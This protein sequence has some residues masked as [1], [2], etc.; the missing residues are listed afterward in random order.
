M[1]KPFLTVRRYPY[2]E[3]L[4]TQIEI[5]ASNG[6]FAGTTDIY[7][8]VQ[9]LVEIGGGLKNFPKTADDEYRY[10][11]RSED[12]ALRCY[13]YFL[14][15]AYTTDAVGH[16]ALQIKMNCNASQPNEGMCEFSIRAE[17]AA[18]NRLGGLLEEFSKLG[19]LELHWRLDEGELF[20]DLQP[21]V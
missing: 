6:F 12:P 20:E 16:S 9:D 18:I 17:A 4:N 13:R 10:E 11:H 2:E 14:L 8:A 1:P 3:P 15:R 7:C 19:H 5:S 21:N